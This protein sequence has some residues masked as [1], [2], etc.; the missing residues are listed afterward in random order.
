MN[1]IANKLSLLSLEE[2]ADIATTMTT[3][4]TLRILKAKIKISCDCCG[5][6]M[7]RAKSYKVEATDKEAAKI[8]VSDK[9]AKWKQGLKGQNCRVCQSIIDSI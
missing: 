8:E 3:D 6:S 2:V 4:T 1:A 9:L 7:P 5:C